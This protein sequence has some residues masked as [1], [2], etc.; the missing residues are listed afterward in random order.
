MNSHDLEEVLS[1]LSKE[2]HRQFLKAAKGDNEI[3]DEYQKQL[4][5]FI[6]ARS[7]EI[8]GNNSNECKRY[9]AD[10]LSQLFS[11][12]DQ[13]IKTAGLQMDPQ[14]VDITMKEL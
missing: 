10:L 11:E 1:D 12:F 14:Q 8:S 3:I 4:S 2:S 5:E 6:E 13:Q 7:K 9:A